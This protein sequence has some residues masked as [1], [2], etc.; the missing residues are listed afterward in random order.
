[1]SFEN[2]IIALSKKVLKVLC[3][4]L[5]Q[6]LSKCGPLISRLASPGNFL[7]MQILGWHYA[8]NESKT[9]EVGF[10][11]CVLTSLILMPARI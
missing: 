8:S 2:M 5:D 4:R 11:I 6:W 3:Y 1:M 7:Q 9:L 10:L